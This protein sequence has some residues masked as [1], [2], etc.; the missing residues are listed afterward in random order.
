MKGFQIKYILF[1]PFLSLIGCVS[2]KGQE[3][4]PDYDSRIPFEMEIVSRAGEDA[5]DL[6]DSPLFDYFVDGRSIIL[7]SQRGEH[8]SLNFNEMVPSATDPS[9]MVPNTNL[10]KYVYY[11]NPDAT[12]E[13]GFNFQPYGDRAL[14][15]E[16]MR[17]NTMN[18]AYDLGALFYPIGYEVDNA[19]QEDQSTYDNLLRS[20]VMAAWHITNTYH[21]RL[22]FRFYHLMTALRVTLLIPVWNPEDNTGFGENAADAAYTL[23]VQK[24]FDINWNFGTSEE[25]PSPTLPDTPERYTIKMYPE[26]VSNDVEEIDLSELSPYFSEYGIEKVRRATFSVLF[27]PQQTTEGM[28]FMRFVLTTMGGTE[29]SYLWYGTKDDTEEGA[30]LNMARSHLGNLVLFLPRYANNAVLVRS[31]IWPWTEAD[32]EFTVIPEDEL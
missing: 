19:V 26:S 1:L 10:Y 9:E 32:S 30:S 25:P 11:T 6:A 28:A 17:D 12:W 15:W 4:D 24:D 29:K 16:Q 21:D 22:R 13:Q 5:A 23:N 20:N 27:P 2:D 3:P 8:I 31:N 14:D 18:G 7:I